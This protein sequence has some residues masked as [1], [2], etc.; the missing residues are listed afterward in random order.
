MSGALTETVQLALGF[1]GS[2]A[3]GQLCLG[4]A[5][6]TERPGHRPRGSHAIGSPMTSVMTGPQSWG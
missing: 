3:A 6:R 1:H 5:G 2:R 4:S